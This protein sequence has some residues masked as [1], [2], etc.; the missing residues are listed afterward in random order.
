MNQQKEQHGISSNRYDM[1]KGEIEL[2]VLGLSAELAF[3]SI[4]G[5]EPNFEVTLHGDGGYDFVTKDGLTI[6]VKYRTKRGTDFAIVAP[7]LDGMK[8]D[9]G[10]LMWPRQ[11][12]NEYEF[13]GWTTRVHASQ[14][15]MVKRLLKDRYLIR[16][17]DLMKPERFMEI[18]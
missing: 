11:S 1:S 2:H 13:V 16:W 10:V 18:L 15:G 5:L 14:V 9:I 7:T 3:A 17:Q 8:A 6:E 4:T 12:A